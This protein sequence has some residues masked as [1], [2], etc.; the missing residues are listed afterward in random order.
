[1]NKKTGV[2]AHQADQTKARILKAAVTVFA[3]DGYAGGRIEQISKEAESNDRM[4]YYYFSSKENLFVRFWNTPTKP[5]TWPKVP[6]ARTCPAP[7][8]H[9]ANKWRFSGTTT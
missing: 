7:W 8:Q 6:A 5:S 9:C 1:M 4:I 2:R 3:R